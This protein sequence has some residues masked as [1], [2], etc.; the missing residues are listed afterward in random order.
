MRR[1]TVVGAIV[2]VVLT[3]G[4]AVVVVRE[5]GG[6]PGSPDPARSS[7]SSA[8]PTT[9]RVPATGSVGVEIDDGAIISTDA[10]LSIDLTPPDGATE[11]Q[12]STDPGFVGATWQR[13]VPTVQLTVPDAGYQMVF[14]RA[15]DDDGNAGPVS[16]AGIEV[17]PTWDSA[18]ASADGNNHRA[19]WARL[20]A[21][22]VVQVR[23]ESGRVA[24]VDGAAQIIGGD[25]EIGPLYDA[26][27]YTFDD[28][29]IQVTS[30]S[31][32]N[33]PYGNR[34][35]DQ[36]FTMMRDWVLDLADPLP[37]GVPLTLSFANVPVDPITFSIDTSDTPSP[38]VQVNQVGFAPN[39]GGKV[40]L[41]SGWTGASGGVDLPRGMTFHVYDDTTGASVLAGTTTRRVAGP[42]GDWGK[43]DLTGSQVQ[44]ADFSAL[45]TPGRY[46][47]CVDVLGCSPT[48]TISTDTTWRHVLVDVARAMYHQR[49]GIELGA[50]YTSVV[51][52]R[53]FHADDGVTF[54]RVS[55]TMLDHLDNVGGDDRFDEYPG[56]TTGETVQG[57]FG[58]HFDAGDWNMRI[59]HLTY[60]EDALDLVQLYPQMFEAMD[61]NIPESTNSI[62][63]LIDEGL[64]DLDLFRRLQLPDGGVP[65]QVDQSRFGDPD[66]ASWDNDVRVFVYSPDVW[67]TYWYAEAAARAATVLRAYDP[68][69]AD[70]Y[71]ASAT[72]A[73]TWA[74]TTWAADPQRAERAAA[75]DP[76]RA[77]AAVAMLEM[78]GDAAWDQVFT[79]ASSLDEGIVALDCPGPICTAAWRYALL[80]TGLGS[81]AIRAN[82]ITTFV[83]SAD[84]L[85]AGQDSSAYPWLIEN[86]G[87][88]LIW[89]LG[90]STPHGVTMLRAYVLTNDERYRTSTVLGASFTLGANPMGV[91]F[92]TGLGSNPV[93]YPL[94]VDTIN[95]GVATWPGTFVFGVH[96]VNFGGTEWVTENLRNRGV[97]PDPVAVPLLWSWYDLSRFPPMNEFTVERS[98]ASALWTFGVLAA[99]TS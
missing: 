62:P 60:L 69:L 27:S 37:T 40:A 63:D 11:V 51:R 58:G 4:A 22:D 39:D 98:S 52:P 56:A 25:F 18:T 72:L 76:R 85:L 28:T 29:R 61:L 53:P 87:V 93:R 45:T 49:S 2:A 67:S 92:G 1:T 68:D 36:P 89:G 80:P 7:S 59:Q 21:P 96:D 88:P 44:Q 91:S 83:Q 64:W 54:E 3:G 99:T 86:P 65:G 5:S 41:V 31:V 35:D 20:L 10:T 73:M 82:A 8:A 33:R 81:E 50:P 32:V 75:V 23:I 55:L 13:I 90:P 15:R 77:A 38:A 24:W 16:A 57:V 30:V 26:G 94:V 34:A 48:F 12:V 74:E 46:R 14:V 47:L 78:T 19:S 95:R 17:D 6:G 97:Q 42:N 66:E 70:Q 9:T 84:A 71:E 43:G 79:E